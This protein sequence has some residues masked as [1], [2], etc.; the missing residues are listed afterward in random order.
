MLGEPAATALLTRRFALSRSELVTS[1]VAAVVSTGSYLTGGQPYLARGVLGD[2][3]GFAALAS[4]AA[5]T[6]RRV[7]HEAAFCLTAI[8][9]VL[10]ANPGWPLRISEARWW[11]LFALGLVSYLGVRRR[12]C[13]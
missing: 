6:H 12:M 10:L 9:G 2:L 5:R 4:V 8:A 11:T 3:I 1:G 7:R 13:D